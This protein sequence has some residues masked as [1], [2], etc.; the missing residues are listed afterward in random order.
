MLVAE[1]IVVYH[2]GKDSEAAQHNKNDPTY[3]PL[4]A[5]EYREIITL[6]LNLVFLSRKER[7]CL[8][9]KLITVHGR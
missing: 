9:K 5:L 1:N 8:S 4:L 6:G 3:L 7:D 2:T